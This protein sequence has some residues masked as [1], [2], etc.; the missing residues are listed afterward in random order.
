MRIDKSKIKEIIDEEVALLEAVVKRNIP[1]ADIA[2]DDDDSAVDTAGSAL[3]VADPVI[4]SSATRIANPNVASRISS[5]SKAGKGITTA[6]K[7][8]GPLA[9]AG[10]VR[11]LA[12]NVTNPALSGVQQATLVGKDIADVGMGLASTP[13]AANLAGRVAGQAGTRA[14]GALAG[15]AAAVAG[16]GAAGFEA[17]KLASKAIGKRLGPESEYAKQAGKGVTDVDYRPSTAKQVAQ[18]ATTGRTG[19]GGTIS[20]PKSPTGPKKQLRPGEAGYVPGKIT[21]KE[22]KRPMK[23]ID[24]IKTLVVQQLNELNGGIMDPNMVPFV[25]H[26]EPAADPPKEPEEDTEVDRLY[27]IAVKARLATEELVKALDDPIHDQAYDSAFKA[28][29]ALRDSL[30]SLIEQGANPIDSERIVAPPENEQPRMDAPGYAIPFAGITY[31]G[32][33]V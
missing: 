5:T 29:M 8:L 25:P 11:S 15:P 9:A 28:T 16:A 30:N 23:S 26:R 20:T 4:G 6:A 7:A 14:V 24:L 10:A 19:T 12:S 21:Y 17:G 2:G 27:R 33:N 3:T 18:Y 22:G 31:S 1:P 13:G 32:D